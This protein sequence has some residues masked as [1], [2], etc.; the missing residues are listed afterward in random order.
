MSNLDLENLTLEQYQE[1]TPLTDPVHDALKEDIASRVPV[2][3]DVRIVRQGTEHAP[4][5]NDSEYGIWVDPSIAPM[6]VLVDERIF[7]NPSA[8]VPNHPQVTAAEFIADVTESFYNMYENRPQE[9]Q[10]GRQDTEMS[11]FLVQRAR[12]ACDGVPIRFDGDSIDG[13]ANV[14][15]TNLNLPPV[16]RSGGGRTPD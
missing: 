9:Q 14:C 16:E 5:V 10:H 2:E 4:M 3:F 1:L 6:Q 12:E 11:E 7:H 8:F 13:R 15:S